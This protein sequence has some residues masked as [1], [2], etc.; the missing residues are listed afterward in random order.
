MV[1]AVG[2]TARIAV[3]APRAAMAEFR[4]IAAASRTVRR[5]SRGPRRCRISAAPSMRGAPIRRHD[6]V[7]VA[8]AARARHRSRCS[9][10]MPVVTCAAADRRPLDGP[11]AAR[12]P[13]GHVDTLKL[14]C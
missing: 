3:A 4:A 12:G 13:P 9:P 7:A 14:R 5:R 6:A 10:P 2:M 8:R 1:L 11:L